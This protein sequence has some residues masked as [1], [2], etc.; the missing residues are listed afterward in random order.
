MKLFTVSKTLWIQF[1]R[2]RWRRGQVIFNSLKSQSPVVV[3]VF[4]VFLK[5]RGIYPGR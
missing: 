1:S 3:A 2:E 5:V 4:S